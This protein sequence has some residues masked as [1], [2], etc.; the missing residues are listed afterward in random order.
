M[1]KPLID[2]MV[3]SQIPAHFRLASEAERQGNPQRAEWLEGFAAGV[4]YIQQRLAAP[5]IDPITGVDPLAKPNPECACSACNPKA[6]WMV[7]CSKCGNKRC[8]HA[9]SHIYQC[10]G[11]NAP[12]QIPTLNPTSTTT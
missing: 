10:T 4:E 6:W 7:L 5:S 9:E 2:R 12:N 3:V 8:P 11:S 1:N